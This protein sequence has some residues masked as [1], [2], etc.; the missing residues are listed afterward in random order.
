MM[1][2]VTRLAAITAL[3]LGGAGAAT[4]AVP[5]GVAHATQQQICDS[6]QSGYC[7]NDW[8][9]G[10]SGTSAP[11]KLYTANKSNEDFAEQ[12]IERCGGTVVVGPNCPFTDKNVDSDFLGDPIVQIKYYGSAGGCMGLK[13]V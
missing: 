6:S 7:L 3:V 8:S 9:N 11:I 5:G 13:T 4:L 1:R 2:R 12:P 10:G